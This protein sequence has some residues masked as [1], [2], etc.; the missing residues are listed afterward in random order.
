MSFREELI[1]PAFELHRLAASMI[2]SGLRHHQAHF[3]L[4]QLGTNDRLQV[5]QPRGHCA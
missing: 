3:K 1:N 4:T 5:G 2:L